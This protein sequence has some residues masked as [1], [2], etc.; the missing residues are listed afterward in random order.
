MEIPDEV[1]LTETLGRSVGS[2]TDAEKA[3][4]GGRPHRR[5]FRPPHG[6][7]ERSMDR[8][9]INEYLAQTIAQKRHNT[10]DETLYGWAIVTAAAAID[11][12]R[13][14]K[15]SPLDD[16]P[17]HSDIVFPPGILCDKEELKRQ[18]HLLSDRAC[19]LDTSPPLIDC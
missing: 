11:E 8:V 19:W 4:R 5:L 16:N 15:A 14:V 3:K 18:T 1:G 12:G 13:R 10:R 2:R 9:S 17:L 6:H 7:T